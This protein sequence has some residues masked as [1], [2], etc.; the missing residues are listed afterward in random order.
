MNSKFAKAFL[1]AMLPLSGTWLLAQNEQTAA[2]KETTSVPPGTSYYVEAASYGTKRETDPPSYTRTLAKTGIRGVETID[3]LDVGLDYRTRFEYRK[4]DLRRPVLTT[5]YPF[6]L[7]TR[8][9]IGVKHKLD[10]VRFA[11]EF[12][13]AHRVN[14][15]FPKDDRDFNR[16]EIIQGYVELHFKKALGNDKLGNARPVF[17]R[18][19]RQAFEFLDRRLLASNQWRNTTNNFFGFRSAIGQEKNDWQIDLLAVRPIKRLIDDFDKTDNDRDVWAVI[20][21]WRRWSQFITIEPYYLGLNQRATVNTGNR[22]RLIHSPGLRVYGWLLDKHI[23][24]DFTYTQQ[25]GKD[26]QLEH[27]AFSVTGE[28]GYVLREMSWKPRFSLF[29]GYVTGDKDPND[30]VNNRFERFYGFARPWS[31]DDYIIM[32]NIITPKLKVEFEPVKGVKIDGGY[33]YYWLASSTD[34]FN[35]LLSGVQNR[36]S[37]GNSGRFLG[38]GLDS[39]VRFKP[40]KFMD[41][42]IGYIHFTNGEFV[43]NRQKEVLGQHTK[44]SDFIYVELCLN[45][46]D[47]FKQGAKK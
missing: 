11:I 44:S 35:N 32:E 43:I 17:V 13:D 5:D 1:I 7:R 12:E 10:P 37:E 4:N 42:N 15:K 3:W 25:F 18:F 28:V 30:K 19:G 47:I 36:D 41:A 33:S 23:N 40:T 6:L 14:G 45:A 39:R 34:R 8:A 21:H 2:S 31:S 29:F 46:F 24:Y 26:S 20:G 38:H 9:Y 22:D 27:K 16:V